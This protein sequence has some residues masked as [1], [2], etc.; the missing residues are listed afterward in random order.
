MPERREQAE[1]GRD[2]QARI[3]DADEAAR[4]DRGE[5]GAQAARADREA[6]LERGVAEQVWRKSGSIAVV[7]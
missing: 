4:R 2:D 3:H 5:Q 1:A 7:A 6:G